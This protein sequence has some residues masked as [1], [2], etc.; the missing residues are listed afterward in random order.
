MT[1]KLLPDSLFEALRTN[2]E[3]EEAGESV[4]GSIQLLR[5][6]DALT[7]SGRSRP[8][9]TARNLAR[10]ASANLS[11]ARLLEGHVNALRIIDERG[12]DDQRRAVRDLVDTGGMLGVW[13]ADGD[14]PVRF[15]PKSRMLNGRKIYAS[16]L[17]T[18]THALVTV[19][20]NDKT[21]LCLIDVS[22]TQRHDSTVWAMSGMRA[23]QSGS[24]DFSDMPADAALWIG[25][26]DS[27][28]TEPTFVGGVWRIAALQLG[29][30]LGLLDAT[31]GHLKRLD[32]M[33]SDAQ[34]I[35]LTPIVMRALAAEQ[36]VTRAAIFAESAAARAQPERAV[37]LSATAR[38]L[39]E[40]LGL[41][42]IT[43]CEQ[44]LG[45]VHFGKGSE[46]G[47][48]ARDL[49]VYMRQAAR[50]ALLLRIGG[51]VFGGASIWEIMP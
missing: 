27:Y 43:A 31:A 24:F 23:T 6:A 49:A 44:S 9:L 28:M 1:A 38:L 33:K 12:N 37:A 35:R 8:D 18:V 20:V 34:L 48:M 25:P 17:G 13:G 26:P 22:E 50:D 32:R 3:I 2:A 21:Q 29:A 7:D 36:L 10:V 14:P 47:R 15:D 30:T 39:T 46:S 19:N 5:V 45:L 11:V 4:G 42:A 16:G 41:H 40:E 51:H